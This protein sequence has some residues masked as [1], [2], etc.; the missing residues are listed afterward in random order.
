[1]VQRG[2]DALLFT[3]QSNVRYITG[4]TT[5][6]WLQNTSPQF[7]LL[8]RAGSPNLIVGGIEMC[9]AVEHPWIPDI[10]SFSGLERLGVSELVQL[11][12]DLDLENA[13]IGAESGSIFHMGMAFDDY[14]AVK[15]ALPGVR[16]VDA[17][18]VFWKARSRKSA[19]EVACL[20]KA[21]DIT[22]KA[23]QDLYRRVRP[24]MTEREVH[25]LMVQLVMAH[26]ADHQGSIPVASRSPGEKRRADGALRPQTDRKIRS[27]DLIWMDAGCIVD[28]YWSRFD[29]NVLRRKGA[30]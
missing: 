4:Y 21:C 1:M 8:P 27:G 16:F 3:T 17:S 11:V 15:D 13:V 25:S 20:Q 18:S 28:G 29:A 22:D 5:H 7:G 14:Q 9:R 2:L 30:A 10:R 19:A 26:G 6:R 23:L 24:G 12:K